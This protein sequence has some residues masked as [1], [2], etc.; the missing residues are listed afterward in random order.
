[1]A[2]LS[3]DLCGTRGTEKTTLR[4]SLTTAVLQDN[5]YVLKNYFGVCFKKKRN[6]PVGV[7]LYFLYYYV[8]DSLFSL[9][10]GWFSLT[11]GSAGN[12]LLQ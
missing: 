3:P 5:F 7:L 9:V 4:F 2:I 1:M 6:E 10:Q 11:A 12:C 8:K